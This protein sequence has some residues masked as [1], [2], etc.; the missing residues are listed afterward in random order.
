MKEIPV[1]LFTGFLD[2]GKTKLISDTLADP[3]FNTGEPML[4]IVCEEGEGEYDPTAFAHDNVTMVT[5]DDEQ[6]LTPDRLSAFEK[7]YHP[8]R[9]L[10]E[11][12]GMWMLDSL[13]RNLPDNWLIY[14][15]ITVADSTTFSAY[16]ANMRQLVF[17]KLQSC[18]TVIFNRASVT[19]DQEAFHK[20][21]RAV[22]RRCAIGYEMVDGSFVYDEI[23]DPLPFDI[24]ADVIE[25]GDEDYGVWY[26]DLTE[27]ISK[28]DGKTVKFRGIVARDNKLPSKTFIVGRHVMTCCADDITYCGLACKSA[29]AASLNT[30]DWVVVTAKISHEFSSVYGSKGPVLT[31]LTVEMST[32]PE[33][34][35]ATM[36]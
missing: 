20:I 31:A 24:N 11:F 2:A 36:Y 7:R 34:P 26:R 10:I 9:I 18:E 16:N 29:K 15:E 27:D 33:Q 17:D 35:L 32:Q 13:Y 23:E 8:D 6:D 25:I 22:N 5:V 4:L 28:Y 12:N 14:Q 21:I 19:T 1:Y 30:R 3:E